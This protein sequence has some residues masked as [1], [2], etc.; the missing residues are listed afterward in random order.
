MH[1]FLRADRVRKIGSEADQVEHLIV[2][3]RDI[4]LSTSLVVTTDRRTYHFFLVSSEGEFMHDVTF[5]YGSDTPSPSPTLS[6][7]SAP[8]SPG[9]VVSDLP[10]RKSHADADSKRA[11]L[12]AEDP[13]SDDADQSYTVSGRAEWKPVSV[14]SKDGKT[15]LEMAASVRHKE[16]PV[17]FEEKKAGWWHHEKVLLGLMRQRGN[18]LLVTGAAGKAGNVSRIVQRKTGPTSRVNRCASLT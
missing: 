12:V 1:A 5:L 6:A 11:K 9:Q 8:P 2:K 18:A 16:A 3:P 17:L 10:K 7:E 4:G 13:L 14:Y 15:Y